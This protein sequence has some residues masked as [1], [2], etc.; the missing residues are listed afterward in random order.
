[1]T[2]K[3]ESILK[4][5]SLILMFYPFLDIFIAYINNNE[6]VLTF[7]I[8]VLS[9]F[10]VLFCLQKYLFKEKHKKTHFL[11]GGG[12][13]LLVLVTSI[14]ENLI[15]DNLDG[16]SFLIKMYLFLA[17][18][19]YYKETGFYDVFASFLLSHKMHWLLVNIGTFVTLAVSLQHSGKITH[20]GTTVISG[21][22]S[23]AH[24]LSYVFLFLMF[25][26]LFFY[27]S[28]RKMLWLIA[29]LSS[30]AIVLLTGVRTALLAVLFFAFVYMKNK[31]IKGFMF[32]GIALALIFIGLYSL[33]IFDP[34]LQKTEYAAAVS[35]S[36]SNGRM[37]IWV[38]SIAA[39]INPPR[40]SSFLSYLLG[41]GESALCQYNWNHIGIRIQAHNDFITILVSYGLINVVA[42]ITMLI[43]KMPSYDSLLTLS[44]L[45]I[46]NGF[47]TYGQSIILFP[48][49]IILVEDIR[50][51]NLNVFNKHC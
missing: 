46:F 47:I 13:V 17:V 14:H 15:G 19:Y 7:H 43:K 8:F 18:L 37:L 2:I 25:G 41:I 39:Y 31:G 34:I 3:K 44:A 50:H 30:L 28:N 26:N 49:L 10:I 1:M 4:I 22:Y 45:I 36:A 29:A 20:W 16:F 35:G 5:I 9:L 51:N 6:G 11:V 48:L 21:P 27:F 33:G 40:G 42:Y 32:G 38:T 24:S 23:L 12:F